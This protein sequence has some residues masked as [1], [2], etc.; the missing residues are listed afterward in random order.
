[1][2]GSGIHELLPSEHRGNPRIHANKY[3]QGVTDAMRAED[4][5]L[6]WWYRSQEMGGWD[7]LGPGY[8]YDD[9]R[10]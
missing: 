1:M 6:H 4:R 2:P 7:A 10:G 3:N 8:Y 5:Q 9:W